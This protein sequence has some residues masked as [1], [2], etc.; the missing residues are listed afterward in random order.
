MMVF[1]SRHTPNVKAQE[2]KFE[3]GETV[4][5]RLLNGDVVDVTIDSE[6]MM[7]DMCP[8]HGYEGIFSDTKER[9]FADCD[10]IIEWARS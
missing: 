4:K 5:Y 6:P 9:G 3:I 2:V 10:R 1:K 7:H 8:T